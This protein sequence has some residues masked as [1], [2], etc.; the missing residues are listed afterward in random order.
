MRGRLATSRET[1][2]VAAEQLVEL[3]QR[4][5]VAPYIT[6][7]VSYNGITSAFQADD[8]GSIP[9]TRSPDTFVGP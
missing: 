3:V 5:I 9:P 6:K 8:G 1:T 4:N 7:R 2:A